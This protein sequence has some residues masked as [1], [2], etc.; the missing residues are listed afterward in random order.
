MNGIQIGMLGIW[1]GI[2]RK[3]IGIGIV[4]I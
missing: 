3:G 2:I 4:Q 1:I